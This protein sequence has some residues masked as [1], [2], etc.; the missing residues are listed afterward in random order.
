LLTDQHI[1]SF[2]RIYATDLAYATE[3]WKLC[4]DGHCC[5]FSRYKSSFKFLG[6]EHLQELP[7]LPGEYEYLQH[8]NW[9]PT[10]ANSDRRTITYD[11]DLGRLNI[12]FLLGKTKTCNCAHDTRTTTC[13]L[14]PLLPLFDI[15]GCLTGVDKNF[16]YFEELEQ[17]DNLP[18]ACKLEN[19]PFEELPK[20]LAIAAE[21]A[22]FPKRLFYVM[23]YAVTKQHAR[24]QLQMM[25]AK[26]PGSAF[27]TFEGAFLVKRLL[28]QSTLRPQLNNLAARFK[29]HYGDHFVLD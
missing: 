19:I 18:R 6:K 17:L 1:Q 28:D 23:A 27:V 26:R 12:D 5:N 13:R 21:I 7:L 3:C 29:A 20:L 2:D 14:Y 10:F 15:E 16:G 9:L 11:L 8:R 24:Q 25:L 4:G 22:R